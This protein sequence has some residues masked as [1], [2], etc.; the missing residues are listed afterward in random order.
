MKYSDLKFRSGLRKKKVAKGNIKKNN[1]FFLFIFDSSEIKEEE[2]EKRIIIPLEKIKITI[3]VIHSDDNFTKK[4]TEII[5][6]IDKR[7]I[8]ILNGLEKLNKYS[9]R[10]TINKISQY[11]LVYKTIF[12]EK[13]MFY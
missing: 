11:I 8:D 1:L 7:I 5:T 4:K 9:N 2:Y 6:E 10:I 13:W 3:V 12:T